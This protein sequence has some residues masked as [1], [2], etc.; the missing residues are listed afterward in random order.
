MTSLCLKIHY[1]SIDRFAI[2]CFTASKIQSGEL[3]RVRLDYACCF[4][5]T[6][7][8]HCSSISI[9][10]FTR[11]WNS[12]ID[13]SQSRSISEWRLTYN[14]YLLSWIKKMIWLCYIGLKVSLFCKCKHL[15]EFVNY[16]HSYLL[17]SRNYLLMWRHGK[18]EVPGQTRQTILKHNSPF[19]DEGCHSS[20]G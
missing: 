14:R 9:A 2:A 7:A 18:L 16:Q 11:V 1:E 6:S 5:L 12:N 10:Y 15:G 17:W 20:T 4:Q 13:M 3:S 8:T 19:L